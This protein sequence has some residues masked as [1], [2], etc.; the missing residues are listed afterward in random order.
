M[1]VKNRLSRTLAAV[2]LQPISAGAVLFIQERLHLFRD[3]CQ[4]D[5]FLVADLKIVLEMSLGNHE[6]MPFPDGEF[7][8]DD[9]EMFIFQDVVFGLYA[10]K[11]AIH[12]YPPQ[13]QF[14]KSF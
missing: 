4:T 1:E 9:I 13:D 3:L 12:I 8:R 5:G 6:T 11:Y 7:V 2:H 10:A 14:I